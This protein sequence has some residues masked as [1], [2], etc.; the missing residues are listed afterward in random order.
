MEVIEQINLNPPPG[1]QVHFPLAAPMQMDLV[2]TWYRSEPARGT[3]GSGRFSL[4]YGNAT[5]GVPTEFAIDLTEHSR[6]RTIG[7]MAGIPIPGTGDYFFRIELREQGMEDWRVVST[8]PLTIS[9]QDN[10]PA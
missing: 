3:R 8:L 2:S 7:R 1:Q 6:A 4:V 9:V 10:R 5:V